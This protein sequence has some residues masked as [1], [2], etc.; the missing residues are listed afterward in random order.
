[1]RGLFGRELAIVK[2]QIRGN[3][4]EL[5]IVCSA[6]LFLTLARYHSLGERWSD[7][8]VFYAALPVL[9]ILLVL[10]RNPLD[11]GLRLGSWRLWLP[12][13][14][15]TCLVAAP[16]LVA[17]SRVGSLHEY[18][19]VHGFDLPS[20][21]VKTV[22]YLAAWEFVFRGYLLFGLRQ[23]FKEASILI[24]VIPFVLL[25]LGKP[26]LETLSTIPMGLYLGFVA[27]RGGSF[28]P[29]VIIHVFINISFRV[30]VNWL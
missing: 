14:V 13:V 8:A 10:R 3:L 19:S 26:E 12:Y 11:F 9:T 4:T 21:A 18:Y 25:H 5:I 28:W 27:Y 22:V 15:V 24:Q 29:A 7:A 17:A 6:V 2:S 1:M 23:R 16:I 30:L 20:Y